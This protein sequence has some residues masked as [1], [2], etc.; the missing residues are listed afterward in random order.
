MPYLKVGISLYT[1]ALL[2]GLALP[3]IRLSAEWSASWSVEWIAA[4]GFILGGV[5]LIIA[6]EM[7]KYLWEERSFLEFR[8]FFFAH[9]ISLLS[10]VGGI[11]WLLV[12]LTKLEAPMAGILTSATF[13]CA[14]ILAVLFDKA[15]SK[16]S[17][18]HSPV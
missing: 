2:L 16:T 9:S 15:T 14:T 5:S 13:V 12:L 1:I 10:P 11:L 6:E 3:T 17:H 18:N 8:N 7:W 4:L